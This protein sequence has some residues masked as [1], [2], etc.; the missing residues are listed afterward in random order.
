M[1]QERDGREMG[2]GAG[3]DSEAEERGRLGRLTEQASEK[4]TRAKDGMAAGAGAVADLTRDVAGG[5]RERAGQVVDFV[6]ESEVDGELKA[7]VSGTTERSLD[8][9]GDA[10]IGAAPTIGRGAEKA[11]EK[12]GG[13]LHLV[14]R[15]LAAVLGVIAGTLGGWWKH[16]SETEYELPEAEEQACRTHFATVTV[17]PAGMTFDRARSG[18]ALGFL[19]SQHPDYRGRRFDEVEPDLRRGFGQ[20]Y[21]ADYDALREFTRYG[22]DRG[23]GRGF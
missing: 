22:Y 11:V 16:A 4:L 5:A 23:A 9:A 17:L 20:E 14:A 21:A 12:L 18:Y 3:Q 7:T 10:L 8:R 13:A 2:A 1:S 6:R 15:P 19:A